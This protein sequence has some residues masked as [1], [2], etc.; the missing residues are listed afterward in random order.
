MARISFEMR[1]KRRGKRKGMIIFMA[2]PDV[3]EKLNKFSAAIFKDANAR[4]EAILQEVEA[5]KKETLAQAEDEILN[6]AYHLIQSQITSIR[7]ACTREVSI[8]ELESR[9]ILLKKREEIVARVFEDAKARLL[10]YSKTDAYRERFL[11]RLGTLNQ[12][13]DLSG[14]TLKIKS[15]DSISKA[16]IAAVAGESV[17]IEPSEDIQIGL[18]ILVDPKNG[19]IIDETLDSKLLEQ[20]DWF[21]QNSKLGVF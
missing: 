11:S 8:E 17:A 19:V 3:Q 10:D 14:C 13:Y 18:F 15:S 1:Q 4:K 20:H 6:E 7:N 5:Y 9:R 16:D 21:A 2:E 12:T